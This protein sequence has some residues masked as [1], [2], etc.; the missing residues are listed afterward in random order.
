MEERRKRNLLGRLLGAD[1]ADEFER[2]QL[3]TVAVMADLT[4][5]KRERR[6]V[7]TIGIEELDGQRLLALHEEGEGIAARR[8]VGLIAQKLKDVIGNVTHQLVPMELVDGIACT[9]DNYSFRT[10]QGRRSYERRENG[11][12]SS[13]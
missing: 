2:Y 3:E 7:V 13:P 5:R 4:V 11:A 8:Q 6:N 12:P 9:L 1:L 10:S